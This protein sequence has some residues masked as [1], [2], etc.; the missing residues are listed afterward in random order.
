MYLAGKWTPTL[1]SIAL[2]FGVGNAFD[3]IVSGGAFA[4]LLKKRKSIFLR[5]SNEININI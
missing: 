4:Y 2:L 5:L 3:S 1:M